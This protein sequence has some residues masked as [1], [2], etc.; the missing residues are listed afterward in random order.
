MNDQH[1]DE[2]KM[3]E[4]WKREREMKERWKKDEREM[5]EKETKRKR[6][7][8]KFH[9]LF[10]KKKESRLAKWFVIERVREIVK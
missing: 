4:R 2:R 7:T 10:G 3:K 1:T 6:K 9:I 8:E 5:K